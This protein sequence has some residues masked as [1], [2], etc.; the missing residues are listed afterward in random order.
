MIYV[1]VSRNFSPP[2]NCWPRLTSPD[3]TALGPAK[4]IL[5]AGKYSGRVTRNGSFSMYTHVSTSFVATDFCYPR[6]NVDPGT[7]I[8]SVTSHDYA[9]DQVR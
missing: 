2:R 5:D 8:L 9:F 6:P 1:P 4:V 7:Y 3:Y